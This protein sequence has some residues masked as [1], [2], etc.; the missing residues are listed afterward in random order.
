MDT[1]E[2]A[3]AADNW[4]GETPVWIED[5]TGGALWWVNC[6]NPPQLHRWS[7]GEARHEHWPMPGRV[8][9]LAPDEDG[10]L[11][12]VLGDGLYD[13]SPALGLRLRVPSP[14]S[15]R[16][17]LHEC[18]TDRHGRFW[19]G[20]Y[21]HRFPA[22]RSAR[23]GAYFRLDGDRLVP[24]IEEI[25]VA[26]GLAFSPDGRTLYAG[27]SPR[28]RIEAFDLDPESG[29]LSN[30]RTFITLEDGPL[31]LDGATVDAGGGYWLALVGGGRLRRYRPDGTVDRDVILPFSNPTKPAF[32]GPGLATLYVTSTKMAINPDAGGADLNGG[33]FALTPGEIGLPEVPVR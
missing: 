29:A 19:V 3:V 12:V 5:E 33:V 30:R 18:A 13:F 22:D 20:A 6:E 32:G 4:L 11:L 25:S 1:V 24:V 23:G 15:G 21:D 14:V 7:P 8:G 9:G 27:D 10:G 2:C 17:R 31:H 16:V 26:N 28:R